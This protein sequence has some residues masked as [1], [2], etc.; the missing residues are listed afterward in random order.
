[1]STDPKAQRLQHAIA[2]VI[3]QQLAADDPPETRLTLQRLMDEGLSEAEALRLIG[4]IV[5]REVLMVLQEGRTFDRAQYIRR[6]RQLPT[7]PEE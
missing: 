4:H 5:V 6:L 3:R 7:L 2:T 1:M